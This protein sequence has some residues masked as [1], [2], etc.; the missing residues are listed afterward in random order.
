MSG[1]TNAPGPTPW[2][3]RLAVLT[4]ACT[5]VLIW[6]GGLVTSTESGL[7]VPDWPL[8]YGM[9]MPPMVG[10]IL[11]E[12]GHRMVATFVG[13]LTMILAVWIWRREPRRWVRRLGLAALALV[14]A[15]GVLGGVTVIY[16][17][18][19]PVSVSHATLAQTFFCVTVLLAFATSWEWKET[20]PKPDLTRPGLRLVTIV[21]TV[22]VYLQLILGALVR[23]S[24]AA[25]AIPDFPLAFGRLI[26]PLDEIPVVLQFTHRLG[27]VV[28]VACMAWLTRCIWHRHRNNRRLV[29]PMVI[30]CCLLAIQVL[31]GGAV[32][33]TSRS[34]WIATAHVATGAL[35]L[36]ISWL[37]TLRAHLHLAPA[38]A[39]DH[40]ASAPE[41]AG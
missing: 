33:W 30:L 21:A 2:L 1:A 8:S 38:R 18:P 4:S 34:V 10:G 28:V 32:V 14:T 3:H 17:L 40:P 5:W 41:S 37:L 35:I 26:P 31:L 24:G 16:L 6:A 29:R 23:H 25:L 12:H 9:L 11:Y 19:T 13:L 22:S 7:A 27:A 20:A 36:A 15:Q 39:C